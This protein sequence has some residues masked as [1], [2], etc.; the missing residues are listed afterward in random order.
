MS[1]PSLRQRLRRLIKFLL[2]TTRSRWR[3]VTPSLQ[4]F[5]ILDINFD[6]LDI[7]T[8]QKVESI[9]DHTRRQRHTFSTYSAT[10]TREQL[11]SRNTR[12]KKLRIYS[13]RRVLHHQV[14]RR[15]IG[16]QIHFMV[17]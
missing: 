12:D 3:R 5:V 6:Y 9:Q 15:M 11:G 10:I 7:S 2:T 13:Q 16:A 1:N 4:R 17:T 8:L 14:K